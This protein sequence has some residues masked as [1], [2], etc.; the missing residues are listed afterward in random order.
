[1]LTSGY[2]I[3]YNLSIKIKSEKKYV[4]KNGN[5]PLSQLWVFFPIINCMSQKWLMINYNIL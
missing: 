2:F 4:P 3:L 1:M 5:F